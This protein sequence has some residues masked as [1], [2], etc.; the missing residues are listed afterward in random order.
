[1]N[2]LFKALTLATLFATPATAGFNPCDTTA[3]SD[4][5][6]NEIVKEH[7]VTFTKNIETDGSIHY[8][9]TDTNGKS[10]I[11]KFNKKEQSLCITIEECSPPPYLGF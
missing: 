5:R 6:M 10:V 11:H 2:N 9:V 1:M 7:G 4:I 8:C 3:N